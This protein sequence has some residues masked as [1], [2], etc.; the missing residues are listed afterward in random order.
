MFLYENKCK[1][2][3]FGWQFSCHLI[4]GRNV[5]HLSLGNVYL[6]ILEQKSER[7]YQKGWQFTC[8]LIT[9]INVNDL[10]NEK[11]YLMLF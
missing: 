11:V 7:L 5:K 2:I 10:S 3:P 9:G 4:T 6:I 8:H 1:V